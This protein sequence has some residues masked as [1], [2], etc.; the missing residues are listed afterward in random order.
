MIGHDEV[1]VT[2]HPPHRLVF[3]AFVAWAILVP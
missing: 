1:C 3:W 2:R